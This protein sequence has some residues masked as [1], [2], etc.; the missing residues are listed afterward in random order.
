MISKPPARASPLTAAISGL[1]KARR[2]MPPNPPEA[3]DTSGPSPAAKA[4]RSIPAEKALSPAPVSTTTHTSGSPVSRSKAL[5]QT[6]ADGGVDGVA[7][8]RP[9]DGQ[10]LDVS[11][12]LVLHLVGHG[13]PPPGPAPRAPTSGDASQGPAGPGPRDMLGP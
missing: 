9:V 5:A 6:P 8:L 1:G 12:A 3:P 7:G 4:F 10:D 2:V 13:S 11:V